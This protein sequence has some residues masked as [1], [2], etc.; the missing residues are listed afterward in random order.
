MISLIAF[1]AGESS[2]LLALEL[3]LCSS[4][5]SSIFRFLELPFVAGRFDGLELSAA[6][7]LERVARL[8][9]AGVVVAAAAS[10]SSS[11]SEFAA[12]LVGAVDD[13]DTDGMGAGASSL[14]TLPFFM[15]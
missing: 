4:M 5:A 13:F 11:S 7:F 12:A 1:V 10:S 14:M 2:L 3:T 8:L 9:V 15:V 6:A